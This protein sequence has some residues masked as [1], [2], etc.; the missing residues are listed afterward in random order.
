MIFAS[1]CLSI[2]AGTFG[3]L[4][5]LGGGVILIPFLTIVMDVPLQT[6]IAISLLSIVATSNSAAARFLGQ[7]LVRI[8]VANF[9]ELGTVL[10]ALVG[11]FIS[12]LLP[13]GVLFIFFGFFLLFSAYQ[14]F[15]SRS[16]MIGKENH[17]LALRFSLS[18]ADEKLEKIPGAWFVMVVAG[19]LSSVL[20]I[21]AGVFKVLAMDRMLKLP[22]KVSTATSNF[23]IGMTASASSFLYLL[24]GK[25]PILLGG[26]V[27]SGMFLG[28]FFGARLVSRISTQGLRRIFV[29]VL[30][31]IGIQ[32]I[33][34]GFNGN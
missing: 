30:I 16:E 31:L 19:I 13:S 5:G 7:D 27:S 4:V 2:F 24:Q 9:L 34:R 12:G 23:M 18:E 15:Q 21:G 26:A 3:T 6:A 14:M 22:L 11:V 29:F 1:F 20:G 17:P 32:M 8:P 33:L 10:G 28:A 25:I